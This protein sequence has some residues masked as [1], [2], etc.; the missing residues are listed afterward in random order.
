MAWIAAMGQMA[1]SAI[2]AAE[3][4]EARNQ[5][6]R[7]ISQS[8]ADYEAMGLPSEEATRLS[9]ERYKSAGVLTPE[10]EQEILQGRT[11]LE[12]IQ[13]D[14]RLREAQMN[15]LSELQQVGEGG[16]RLSDKATTEKILGDIA[17]QERGA[18]GAIEQ[19]MLQRG[20]YGSGAELA[21]KLS[22]QQAGAQ[23]AYQQGLGLSAQAQ[24]R[25]LQA[26]MQGGNLAG[27]MDQQQFNQ[28]QQIKAAQDAI[29]RMNTGARQDVQQRNVA[30]RNAAQAGNLQNAQSILNAN[31]DVANN[32]QMQN[33]NYQQQRFENQLAMNQAKSNARMGQASQINAAGNDKAQMWGGL[34][35]GAGQI[36]MGYANYMDNQKGSQQKVTQPDPNRTPGSDPEDYKNWR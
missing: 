11:E 9:L 6:L 16:Y 25:A 17:Q 12:G 2:G 29:N 3:K 24:D 18:R 23:N 36:G 30:A 19:D 34:G 26:I 14:P 13:S 20:V 1:G 33:K 31:V 5:A 21:S 15:A 35:A 27:T 4:G 28:Q 10:M 22:A 7:L 8:V 32:E